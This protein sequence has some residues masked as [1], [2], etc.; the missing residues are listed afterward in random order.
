M[1][2]IHRVPG[3]AHHTSTGRPI[4]DHTSTCTAALESLSLSKSSASKPLT[5]SNLAQ[6]RAHNACVPVI[7]LPEE[8]LCQ[9]FI[10]LARSC[11]LKYPEWIR[12][13]YVCHF[14]RQSALS[15]SDLWRHIDLT[16]PRWTA[17][18]LDRAGSRPLVVRANVREGTS[19]L[20]RRTVTAEMSRVEEVDVI[21]S[22]DKDFQHVHETFLARAPLL[23]SLKMRLLDSDRVNGSSH[24]SLPFPRDSLFQPNL[25]LV[26]IVGCP[27]EWV[28]PLHVN[29]T[30]LEISHIPGKQRPS[31]DKFFSVLRN[32]NSL[33]HLKLCQAFPLPA[34]STSAQ[35][36][37]VDL[38]KLQHLSLAGSPLE[39]LDVLS[40]LNHPPNIYVGC[41]ISSSPNFVADCLALTSTFGRYVSTRS[42]TTPLRDLS[43]TLQETSHRYTDTYFTRNPDYRQDLRVNGFA[44]KGE[45]IFGFCISLDAPASDE[46]VTRGMELIL[47]ALPLDHVQKISLTGVDNVTEETWLAV[48]GHLQLPRLQ[49]LAIQGRPPTGL[50]WALFKNA[51]DSGGCLIPSLSYLSLYNTDCAACGYISWDGYGF[52]LPMF[53]HLDGVQF[54]DLVRN[55]VAE[56][57]KHYIQRLYLRIKG[58]KNIRKDA[59]QAFEDV[60]VVDWD[61]EGTE[62]ISEDIISIAPI[63]CQMKKFY[64]TVDSRKSELNM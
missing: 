52:P 22:S 63:F 21:F 59:L 30:H 20:F 42:A 14:W 31:R 2:S 36:A 25:R 33:E 49:I 29:L 58:C 56:R 62:E 32:L 60:C 46:T 61:K 17:L 12:V 28:P 37:P 1:L 6:R 55:C 39:V 4:D 16:H 10:A 23:R 13:S 18:T 57:K 50:F 38:P 43:I 27:F 15:C 47:R 40:M 48:L 24:A 53:P 35:S 26:D 34:P 44:G 19:T 3:A 64:Y 54:L 5:G 9:I 41:C 11:S 51:K 8:I 45:P 7:C